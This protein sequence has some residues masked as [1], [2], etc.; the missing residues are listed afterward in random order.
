M[1][2]VCIAFKQSALRLWVIEGETREA[3]DMWFPLDLIKPPPKV[4]F[5][6]E[7]DEE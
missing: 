7:D 2:G 1:D 5:P 6:K 4:L 3:K